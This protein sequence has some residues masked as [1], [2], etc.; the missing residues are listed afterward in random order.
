MDK[1]E[2]LQ[3]QI[4]DIF[5]DRFEMK[6]EDPTL[7]LLETGIV[8]SVKIVELVLELE[9]RFGV[10]LPFEDLEIEDFQTV[11]KLAQCVARTA[12]AAA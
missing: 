11:A 4:F 10:S 1:L 2:Q 7:D 9:Q 8:D 3:Q 12:P 6:L 5:S